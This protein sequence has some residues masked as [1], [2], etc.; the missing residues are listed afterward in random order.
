MVHKGEFIK[1]AVEKSGVKKTRLAY[2]M[3]ISRGTLYNIFK[4]IEVDNDTILKNW[5]NYPL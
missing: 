4:E 1:E 5:L 3:G 2:E